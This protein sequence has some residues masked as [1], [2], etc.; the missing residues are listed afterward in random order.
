MKVLIDLLRD[1]I[2]IVV[3]WYP[4]WLL[5]LE[6]SC[7]HEEGQVVDGT[8]VAKLL[9]VEH[10]LVTTID[11]M[12]QQLSQPP[13]TCRPLLE[14]LEGRGWEMLRLESGQAAEEGVRRMS[15]ID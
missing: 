8:K 4:F 12:R 5:Y 1:G 7:R 9:V 2:L 3:V 14:G 13:L 10:H 15:W 6:W 11:A